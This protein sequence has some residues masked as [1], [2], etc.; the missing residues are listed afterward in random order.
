MELSEVVRALGRRWWIIAA[1]LAAG[2]A[3]SL[4]S[5]AATQPVYR[6]SVGF[7][8]VAPTADRLSALEADN[9]V[10]GRITSY[11]SLVTSDR[12]LEQIVAAT[13]DGV[14]KAQAANSISAFG[15]PTTLLLKVEVNDVD[16]QRSLAM[17]TAV[18]THFGALVN[19]L[20]GRSK[21]SDTET[22]LNVVSGPTLSPTPVEPRKALNLGLG[23]LLGLAVGTGI[24]IALHRGD[25][26]IRKE[27]QLTAGLSL[28]V[29]ATL[30]KDKVAKNAAHM[31]VPHANSVLDEAARR[32]R[33]SIQ[34]H[35]RSQELQLLAVTAAQAG[36]GTTTT[37]LVLAKAVS[38]T[39]RKVL[40]VEA[41]LRMPELAA[42]LGLDSGPG[43]TE[44]LAGTC[45]VG[46][47]IQKTSNHSLDILVAGKHTDR[48]AELLG[49][50]ISE[51]MKTIRER[52]DVIVVDT[53]ALSTWTDAAL[54]AAAADG[55]IVVARHGKTTPA[56]LEAATHSLGSVSAEVLGTVLNA[57]PMKRSQSHE[58][59]VGKGYSDGRVNDDVPHPVAGE[60]TPAG[61]KA[62]TPPAHVGPDVKR[63]TSGTKI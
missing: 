44:V 18:S 9:L 12:F 53:A 60:S 17:A 55:T 13:G 27:E 56:M 50:G 39:D 21:T 38:E 61:V 30:P 49:A 11:A 31:M 1:T 15:D 42:H 6:S 58:V 46:E 25:S 29:L 7:F 43:L 24:A 20:E 34:F 59:M 22:V 2:I 62:P 10:R 16:P 35:P 26:T 54:V 3:I 40:L 5:I 23:V 36:D 8:V 51:L 37:S 28:P 45:E 32:L 57:K 47:A 41:N 4:G 48:P 63:R 52:Y 33:T 19:E 14:T